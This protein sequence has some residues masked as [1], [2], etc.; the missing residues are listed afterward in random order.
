MKKSTITFINNIFFTLGIILLIYLCT[1][2]GWKKILENISDFNHKFIPVLLLSVIWQ[3]FYTAG[4]YFSS[5]HLRKLS[6]F[7]L[8]FYKMAG[9]ASASF[10]PIGAMGGVP[11]K[12]YKLLRS[13]T[14]QEV[15]E[16]LL[17]DNFY[18]LLCNA[19]FLLVSLLLVVFYVKLTP[20]FLGFTWVV[21]FF[22]SLSVFFLFLVRKI[23]FLNLISK[24]S[25]ILPFKISESRIKKFNDVDEELRRVTS[26]K[27]YWLIIIFLFYFMG[28]F[29]SSLEFYLIFY[30]LDSPITFVQSFILAGL[31][32]VI[33]L[34]FFFI[35]S[36][37]GV[38][39]SGQMLL[40]SMLGINPVAGLTMAII[41]R[42]RRFFEIFLGVISFYAK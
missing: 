30:L 16:T 17:I 3:L 35:P 15:T 37:V 9:E 6:I 22:L 29:L 13:F 11:M 32:I 5:H 7:R 26:K 21:I 4:W 38:V 18:Y 39:E 40:F 36:G 23:G 1:D 2:I 19:V 31:T 14:K 27:Y 33:N 25:K 20:F 12:G 34:V 42:L 28:R 10:L 41:R 8:F 24:T